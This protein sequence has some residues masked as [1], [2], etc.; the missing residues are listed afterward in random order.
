MKRGNGL[1]SAAQ[2]VFF[3]CFVLL[4]RRK[5]HIY[6]YIYIYIYNIYIIYI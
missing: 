2:T 3:Y 1:V 6:I 4:R 5:R